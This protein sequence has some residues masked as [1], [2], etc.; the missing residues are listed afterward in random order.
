MHDISLSLEFAEHRQKD[1]APAGV[2]CH[3]RRQPIANTDLPFLTPLYSFPPPLPP[4]LVSNGVASI[5]STTAFVK[6]SGEWGSGF[7][8]LLYKVSKEKEL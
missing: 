4:S 6:T 3:R 1:L 8:I 7:Y 5:S 2:D